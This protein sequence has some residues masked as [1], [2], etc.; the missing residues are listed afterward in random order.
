MEAEHVQEADVLYCAYLS[1]LSET[2]RGGAFEQVEDVEDKPLEDC[3]SPRMQ[4]D[5]YLC[6]YRIDTSSLELLV[7]NA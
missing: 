5:S 2:R 4:K 7:S 6:A 3:L 1:V